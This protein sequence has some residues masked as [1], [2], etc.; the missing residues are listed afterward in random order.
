MNEF[1]DILKI[2]E[3]SLEKVWGNKEDE[4]WNKYLEK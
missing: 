4:I 2:S 1:K 3:K